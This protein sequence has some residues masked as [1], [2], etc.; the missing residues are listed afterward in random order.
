MDKI[1]QM[2]FS[3]F[4]D[5]LFV[6][7]R[8]PIPRSGALGARRWMADAAPVFVAVRL[9]GAFQGPTDPAT[10]IARPVRRSGLQKAWTVILMLVLQCCRVFPFLFFEMQKYTLTI[11]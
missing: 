11:K 6:R 8:L 2:F 10:T 3:A 4:V 9:L 5:P 1:F 7:F